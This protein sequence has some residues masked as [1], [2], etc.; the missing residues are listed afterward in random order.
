MVAK[1]VAGDVVTYRVTVP[2]GLTAEE[3]FA[4]FVAAGFGTDAEWSAL[5]R[6]AVETPGLFP[7]LPAGAPSLTGF[8]FPETYT[9]TRRT[10]PREILERMLRQFRRSLPERFE[11]R[12]KERGLTPLAAVT[13]ASIVEK[14]TAVPAERPLVAGVYLN[15]LA[16]GMLLQ[17]DPTTVFAA[18]RRGSYAGSLTRAD[19]ERDDP[20]NTYRS[21]GLPPGPICS[22]G[23]ASLEAAVA[24]AAT[25]ALYFVATGEGDGGHRFSTDWA[26]HEKNVA[27]FRRAQKAAG[28]R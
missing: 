3:T 12:A 27:S 17:A 21:P 16:R 25:T 26:G 8:L 13:L 10:T 9:L 2:E 23:R 24:P 19:L 4:H 7:E 5:A 6:S 28:R 15:R 20:Y 18:R 14:E 11:E 22:P 1:I